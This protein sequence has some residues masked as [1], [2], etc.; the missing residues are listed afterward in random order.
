MEVRRLNRDLTNFVWQITNL[1]CNSYVT[2]FTMTFPLSML[3][4]LIEI[5][6]LHLKYKLTIIN[7]TR[8]SRE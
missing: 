1:L 2:I 6:Y 3:F 4:A 8:L 7:K 5:C